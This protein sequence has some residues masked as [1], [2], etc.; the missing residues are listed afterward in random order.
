MSRPSVGSLSVGLL[1]VVVTIVGLLSLV[2]RAARE[3]TVAALR[4]PASAAQAASTGEAATP[5]PSPM[6]TATA[7]P[8]PTATPAPTLIP[9]PTPIPNDGPPVGELGASLDRY[10][11]SL[12]EAKLFHGAVLVAHKGKVILSKGYGPANIDAGTTNSANTRFRIASVTKQFTSMAIMQLVGAG[13]LGVDDPLCKY[14]DDCPERWQEITIRHLLNHTHGLPNYTDFPSYEAIQMNHMTPAE[15][16]DRLRGQWPIT[17][18]GEAYAY[19]NTGYLLLGTIIEKVSGQSYRD[20]LQEHIFLPLEMYNSG[21]TDSP[22]PGDNW[23]LPYQSWSGPAPALDT[24]TL[25]ASGSLYSTVEDLYR[26]DQALYTEKLLPRALLNEMFSP[27]LNR[28][29]FGWKIVDDNGHLR[30]GHPG[31][32]D[33]CRTVILRYP[34]D[35]TTVIV[36]ANMHSANS[37]AIGAYLARIVLDS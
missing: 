35:R 22:E 14:I 3:Q 2:P 26:W 18:P 9:S 27:G 34:A 33:G 31:E 17:S 11:N 16:V 25:F 13:K 10:L 8:L 28:Y 32:M 6:P 15:L 36:L 5:R 37:D 23:A 7:T 20:F 29:G 1:V 30:I 4:P 19:G 21:V 12:V 24:S